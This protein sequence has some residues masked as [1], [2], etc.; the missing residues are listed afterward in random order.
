MSYEAIKETCMFRKE[1]ISDRLKSLKEHLKQENSVL[2]EV[3]TSFHNLDYVSR[4]LGFFEKNETHAAQ[5]PWWP[6]VSVLGTYS[7]GKSTF[8]NHY[9]QYNLQPTGTQA[10]DDKFTVICYTNEDQARTLPGLAL[11]SDPRFPLY[12]ISQAI[13]EVAP[14]EGQNADAF[15]QLK[16]CKS[17]NLRG[18]ILIDSPGFDADAQR[19][20]TLRI[21][22]RII[23]LSDLVLVF[24]DA[25]HP[26]SGSMRDTLQHLVQSTIKRQDASKFLYILNQI[27]VSA[28]ED[29]PEQVFAAWQRSLAQYGLTA[30]RYYCIYN[31]QFSLP[32]ENESIRARYQKKRDDDLAEIYSRI[33]QVKVD[34]AYRIIGMLEK[35]ARKLE[36][37]VSQNIR[38]F[39]RNWRH[40]VLLIEG[41]AAGAL[42]ILCLFL[43]LFGFNAGLS[44][45]SSFLEVAFTN[46]VGQVFLL[47][48]FGGMFWLHFF[49]R[50]KVGR[51]V[52]KRCLLKIHDY[53][54]INNYAKAFDRNIRWWL[55]IFRN[56]P[57]GWNKS[58]FKLLAKVRT[59]SKSYIQKLNDIYTD[60]SGKESAIVDLHQA[61]EEKNV[62]LPS[63]HKNKIS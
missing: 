36:E 16:T 25:R 60:P 2:Q 40:Q 38:E 57:V 56:N 24:F 19:T 58:A 7:S 41:L 48:V 18:K 13:E 59:D 23:D 30:G 50:K 8:I 33:E 51:R 45:I 15:L 14:N 54:L 6:L 9:L 42:L 5:T 12:R 21:T 10:V 3:I 28:R 27:D 63:T 49:I 34:R 32:I 46:P 43:L 37:E 47:L 22:D 1:Q 29:N 62:I 61:K 31:P 39:I 44:V 4:R 52:S 55:S 11:D 35:T 53:E 20:S 17:K 26:E